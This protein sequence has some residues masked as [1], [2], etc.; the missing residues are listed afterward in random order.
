MSG[1]RPSTGSGPR[2]SEVERIIASAE[3]DTTFAGK[4]AIRYRGRRST[5]PGA[6]GLVLILAGSIVGLT[7]YGM[8]VHDKVDAKVSSDAAI[9]ERFGT[10]TLIADGRPNGNSSEEDIN[11]VNPEQYKDKKCQQPEY[12]SKNG[13]VFAVFKGGKEVQIDIKGVTW[14]GMQ[15][16]KGVPKGLWDN[17]REGSTLYRVGQF[18]TGNNFNAVRFPLSIDAAMRNTEIDL[19]LIN[20]NSNRALKT[21]RYNKLLGLLAQGLGQFGIGI[22]LDFFTLSAISKDDSALWYGTSIQLDDIKTAITN[23]ATELCNSKHFNVIGIDLKSGVGRTAT[24]GDGSNTDWAAAATELGEH[25][26][27][28]CPQWLAFVGGIQGGSR[29]DKYEGDR[30]IKTKFWPG[31]DLSNVKKTPIKLSKAGKLVYS[32]RYWTSSFQPM[33]YFFD[34]GDSKGDM[35]FKYKESP[36][37]TLKKNVQANMNY[38]FGDALDSGAAVV[39]SAFGGLMGEDDKTPKKTSTRIVQ[40]LLEQMQA[41]EKGLAGGFW[42]TLNP[43][44][45]WS[46]PA[47]DDSNATTAGLLDPTWR[48]ANQ[49]VLKNLVKMDKMAS[50][51]YIPCET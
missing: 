45:V 40:I 15:D 27:K 47:P 51:A 8:K 13:R 42:Y 32:P 12:V 3:V 48:A 41:A 1:Q 23:L 16:N 33:A 17:S 39:L 4:K 29:K 18:L 21:T 7:Y 24:W 50:V 6:L 35:L 44:T 46:Y 37:D 2:S 28:A 26:V 11:V 5:W 36:D 10:G 43:E 22:V 34:D 19:N 25:L 49:N 20:T 31:S 14:M 30:V 38:M 9:R